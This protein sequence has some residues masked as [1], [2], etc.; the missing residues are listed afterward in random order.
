MGAVGRALGDKP[1]LSNMTASLAWLEQ[2]RVSVGLAEGRGL[3]LGRVD[4]Q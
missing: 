2:G 1:D 3:P 4:Y